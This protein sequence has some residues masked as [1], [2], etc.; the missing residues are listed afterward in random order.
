MSAFDDLVAIVARLRAPDGCPWDREQTPASAR[1]FL[2][3]EV[4][5]LVEAIDSRDIDAIREELGDLLFNIVLLAQM[6][7]E[8]GEFDLAEVA[9]GI[10]DKMV[11]RHP[12][13]FGEGDERSASRR[14]IAANW[15]RIKARERAAQAKDPSALDGIPGALPALM[16][17][18]AVGRKAAR[19]GFDWPDVAGP[20]AKID[21]ELAELDAALASGDP[22]AVEDELGDV[23]FSLV[24]LARHAPGP[25]AS[26][27]RAEHA[28]RRTVQK[29][30][31]RFRRVEAL[32]REAGVDI[33]AADLKRLD[34]WWVRA[35]IEEAQ[36]RPGGPG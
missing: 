23:L 14:D 19:I 30:E 28:L 13:V 27:V 21:E 2:L 22:D 35:K 18:Q 32:A 25:E 29:F 9:R 16:R 1:T 33:H 5:E 34:A 7:A 6:Y 31:R 36:A 12:H 26:P 17:A 8:Q 20:R 10:A 15:D 24:N 3:E 4:Y 11:R